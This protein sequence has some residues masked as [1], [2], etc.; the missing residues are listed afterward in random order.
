MARGSTLLT[1]VDGVLAGGPGEAQRGDP[2]APIALT[3]PSKRGD[4]QPALEEVRRG[5]SAAVDTPVGAGPG[6]SATGPLHP[7]RATLKDLDRGGERPPE[8]TQIVTP[9][10]TILGSPQER[11]TGPS[12]RLTG[13]RGS[14][15]RHGRLR[16]HRAVFPGHQLVV[17]VAHPG[18]SS[19][20]VTHG[21]TVA[22]V[23][24][25]HAWAN[26]AD[27]QPLP[28]GSGEAVQSL[29]SPLRHAPRSAP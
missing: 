26:A 5:A 1:A 15:R 19:V 18:A 8:T 29:T 27:A 11:L 4:L 20:E 12:E 28:Q 23:V 7:A 14:A 3:R 22:S 24:S 25:S 2:P 6:H 13:C 16:R 21:A 17:Q 9:R 10:V